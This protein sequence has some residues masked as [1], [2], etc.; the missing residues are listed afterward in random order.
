LK[1]KR[2]ASL[3]NALQAVL[4][5]LDATVRIT[6]WSGSEGIPEPLRVAAAEVEQRLA[7]A[8][9]VASS[10]TSVA[11]SLVQ[12]MGSMAG[13]VGRLDAAY[14]T[15]RKGLEASPFEA[16]IALDQEV[17]EVRADESRWQQ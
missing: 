12:V 6:R 8:K 13:A 5:S 1:D 15:Y 2:V 3:R 16:A 9:Q 7:V 10:N 4:D 14:A 11:P 17:G